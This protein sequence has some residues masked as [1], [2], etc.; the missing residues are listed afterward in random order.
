MRGEEI[1]DLGGVQA[2]SSADTDEP[3]EAPI[4][5][6]VRGFLERF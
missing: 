3:I 2:R 1:C 6:E 5:S 4:R